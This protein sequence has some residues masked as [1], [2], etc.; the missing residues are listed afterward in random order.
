MSDKDKTTLSDINQV[1]D[2]LSTDHKY[3]SDSWRVYEQKFK[4]IFGLR[5]NQ[6]PTAWE[7]VSIVHKYLN[8]NGGQVLDSNKN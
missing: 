3:V 8:G 4:D 7:V 2:V 5:P 6:Q 1:M